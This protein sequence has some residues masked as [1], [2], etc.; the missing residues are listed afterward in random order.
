MRPSAYSPASSRLIVVHLSGGGG[1]DT[2]HVKAR[3]RS[4]VKKCIHSLS[5]YWRLETTDKYAV[6]FACNTFPLQ[7]YVLCNN[8]R[9]TG[10][11]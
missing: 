2:M 7:A 11:W 8:C 1:G 10:T 4:T 6:L 3:N 5:S 9:I